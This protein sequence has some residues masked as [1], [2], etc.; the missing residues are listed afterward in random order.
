MDITTGISIVIGVVAIGGAAYY[1]IRRKKDLEQQFAQISE[2]AKQIPNQKRHSF[3]LYMF[4]ESA[5]SIKSKGKYQPGS[6]A[7]D[8]KYLEVQLIKMSS[9]LKD[10]TKVK[11]KQMKQALQMYDGYLVWEKKKKAKAAGKA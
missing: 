4:S 7:S 1:Y 10:R 5:K 6:R 9:I 11:D 3:M 8:P 2:T